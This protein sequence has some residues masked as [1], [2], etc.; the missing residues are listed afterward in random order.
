MKVNK[1]LLKSVLSVQSSSENDVQ[2]LSYIRNFASRYKL[3]V[4]RD[5]FG[6]LYITK[7]KSKHGYP[8]MVSH[9]DTVHKTY[10]D[11][12]VFE[13]QGSLFAYSADGCQQVGIGGDDKVGVY[14]C[15]QA[16]IDFPRIK[17][18]FF[19]KEEVGCLGSNAADMKFFKNCNFVL[20]LDRKEY[21]DFSINA[22]GV[23][24]NSKEFRKTLKPLLRKW[25]Y[26]EIFTSVTD[27][28]TLKQRGLEVC[29]TNISC[30][31]Y[32]PHSRSEVVLIED[33]NRAYSL[34][35]DII[36][37]HGETRF[38]HKYDPPIITR[39]ENLRSKY[40]HIMPLFGN[41]K[42]NNP[43][44]GTE[45]NEQDREIEY[46]LFRKFPGSYYPHLYYCKSKV[47]F[48]HKDRY[49]FI[50]EKRLLYDKETKQYVD[51]PSVAKS[52]YKDMVVQ[53]NGKEFVFSWLLYEWI[54]KKYAVWFKDSKS[55]WLKLYS[56]TW[57][58]LKQ[59]GKE[60]RKQY[61]T[62]EAIIEKYEMPHQT[63][64]MALRSRAS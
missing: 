30:G 3:K 57:P 55:W 25:G 26:N 6:N 18:V 5:T 53:D 56:S 43:A 36:S 15:L 46:N 32:Y 40:S 8:C 33:V 58:R 14:A 49:L 2:I 24:L 12:K 19:R 34:A 61:L 13:H 10:K 28:M 17:V 44:F 31:Y 52:V 47:P 39:R 4:D 9:V 37:K 64:T 60:K 20:Q 21:Q 54:D 63:N 45:E 48:A 35:H 62:E 7:G 27:V 41:A 22:A 16:L 1:D 42:W 51:D 23:E 50:P 11:F 59:R 29:T 38:E